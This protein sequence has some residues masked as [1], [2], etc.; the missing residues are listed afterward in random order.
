MKEVVK[1]SSVATRDKLTGP[2]LRIIHFDR[3]VWHGPV[4]HPGVAILG[5]RKAMIIL[6]ALLV[7]HLSNHRIAVGLKDKLWAFHA[8]KKG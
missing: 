6:F 5:S 4:Q 2:P 8:F 1:C 3:Y 7:R